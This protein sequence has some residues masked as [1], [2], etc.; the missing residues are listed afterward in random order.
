MIARVISHDVD[1]IAAV[2]LEDITIYS[3]KY[4]YEE[5]ISLTTIAI[6]FYCRDTDSLHSHLATAEAEVDGTAADC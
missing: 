6:V 5:K 3:I 2:T 4:S 1:N